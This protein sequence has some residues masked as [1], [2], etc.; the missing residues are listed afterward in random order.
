MPEGPGKGHVVRLDEMLP[1]Y[2]KCRGWT[3]K[4]VP[5]EKKLAALRI[6]PKL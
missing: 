4:G 2:Y 6:S 1:E 5:T 3:V